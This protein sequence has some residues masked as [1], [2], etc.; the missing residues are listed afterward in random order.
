MILR[1]GTFLSRYFKYYGN[2]FRTKWLE[3]LHFNVI[4]TQNS[5]NKYTW[6]NFNNLGAS[7]QYQ[8]ITNISKYEVHYISK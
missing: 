1:R 5:I 6:Q 7:N 8:I 4:T 3:E 2:I